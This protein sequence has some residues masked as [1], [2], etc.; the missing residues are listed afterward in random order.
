MRDVDVVAQVGEPSEHE[1]AL[2]ARPL[3]VERAVHRAREAIPRAR[4]VDGVDLVGAVPI[5][6]EVDP[7]R[8]RRPAGLFVPPV[9]VREVVRSEEHTSELQ[10]RP[11]LVCRLL[12]EKKTYTTHM[13]STIV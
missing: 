13:A 11:H 9:A 12:L 6:G 3:R 1:A 7:P 4:R 8:L 10:S 2:A 5:R